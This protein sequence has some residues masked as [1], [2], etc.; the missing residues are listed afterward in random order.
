MF[1]L[2]I[3]LDKP[4][5]AVRY[6]WYISSLFDLCVSYRMFKQ[7]LYRK[8]T[9]PKK[10]RKKSFYFFF[11]IAVPLRREEVKVVPLGEKNV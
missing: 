8:F 4:S 9:T 5:L 6:L 1:I 2:G 11:I 10:S 7:G 3:V